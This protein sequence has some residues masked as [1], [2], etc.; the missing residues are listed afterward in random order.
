[1]D[2]VASHPPPHMTVL[3]ST[4][5]PMEINRNEIRGYSSCTYTVV[6]IV[7]IIYVRYSLLV[8]LPRFSQNFSSA[9]PLL[10]ILDPRLR[11]NTLNSKQSNK[12][13]Q[14][15]QFLS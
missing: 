3:A 7:V 8:C 13:Q 1:M 12:F 15:L 10:N 6:I 11:L 5:R 2:R 4:K 9:T 14:F